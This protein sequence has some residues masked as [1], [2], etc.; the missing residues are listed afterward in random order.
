MELIFVE[1]IARLLPQLNIMIKIN[2]ILLGNG[3][4]LMDHLSFIQHDQHFSLLL[5]VD[6]IILYI[7]ERLKNSWW[8]VPFLEFRCLTLDILLVQFI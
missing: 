7:I 5:W 2:Q 1:L 6:T 3:L 8:R 4:S